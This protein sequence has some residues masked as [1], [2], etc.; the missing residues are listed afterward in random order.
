MDELYWFCRKQLHC[1][2]DWLQP[3]L[4]ATSSLSALAQTI[5]K[6][7]SLRTDYPSIQHSWVCS[8]AEGPVSGVTTC[9]WAGHMAANRLSVVFGKRPTQ[10]VSEKDES[11]DI[12]VATD[13]RAK[14]TRPVLTGTGSLA[15]EFHRATKAKIIKCC[16]TVSR[17]VNMPREHVHT[18]CR[19]D[20]T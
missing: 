7:Q 17:R 6:R 11:V 5:S 12:V 3:R 18:R 20:G 10:S 13:R 19:R 4:M 1:P 9:F 16:C 14:P 8:H 2:A 15:R